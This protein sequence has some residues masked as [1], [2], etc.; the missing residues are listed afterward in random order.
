MF[1]KARVLAS[2]K[3]FQPSLLFVSKAGAFPSK[4]TYRCSTLVNLIKFFRSNLNKPRYNLG[5]CYLALPTNIRPGWL[6]LPGSNTLAF[7]KHS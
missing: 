3:P 4:P 5:C 1:V 7:N 2:A 6:S